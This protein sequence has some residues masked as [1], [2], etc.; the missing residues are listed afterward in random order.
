MTNRLLEGWLDEREYLQIAI[1]SIEA[2][3]LDGGSSGPATGLQAAERVRRYKRILAQ[4]NAL[5]ARLK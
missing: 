4:L 2:D 5:I 3:T 1:R